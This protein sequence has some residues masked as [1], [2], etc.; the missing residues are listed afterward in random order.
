VASDRAGSDLAFDSADNW[1]AINAVARTFPAAVA[2]A[3]NSFIGMKREDIYERSQTAGKMEAVMLIVT[4]VA[5]V[6][7]VFAFIGYGWL[8]A[9]ELLVLGLIAFAL[10]RLFDLIGDLF[11]SME[12][13]EEC[14]K[15]RAVE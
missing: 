2:E 3:D 13:P 12:R 15:A 11:G 8:P 6:A 5:L 10:S 1:T 14:A 4:A 7:A 9:L